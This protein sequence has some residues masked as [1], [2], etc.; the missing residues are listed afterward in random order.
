MP[1]SQLRIII[2]QLR[3][4]INLCRRQTLIF[5]SKATHGALAS[6]SAPHGLLLRMRFGPYREAVAGAV[7]EAAQGMDAWSAKLQELKQGFLSEGVDT[8]AV[9]LMLGFDAVSSSLPVSTLLTPT[10]AFSHGL[11]QGGLC[12]T[13]HS[14]DTG[15]LN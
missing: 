5:L 15:Q 3:L 9:D 6:V 11:Y 2:L 10:D 4:H 13:N 1:T 7:V 12:S 14:I 8:Q